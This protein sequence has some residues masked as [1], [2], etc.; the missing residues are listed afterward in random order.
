MYANVIIHLNLTVDSTYAGLLIG[1]HIEA[2]LS[3]RAPRNT[4]SVLTEIV[5]V[6]GICQA[7]NF[8]SITCSAKS[9]HI[10]YGRLAV[11]PLCTRIL[12]EQHDT[13]DIKDAA[14]F[15]KMSPTALAIKARAGQVPAAKVAKQWVFLRLDLVAYIRSMYPDSWQRPLSDHNQEVELWHYLNVDDGGGLTS[16]HLAENEY[17]YQLGLARSRKRENSMTD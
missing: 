11:E 16:Q 13:L 9:E 7:L 10:L 3:I 12:M 6:L 15:L 5:R 17:E 2:L 1:P 14:E 4:F 8:Y